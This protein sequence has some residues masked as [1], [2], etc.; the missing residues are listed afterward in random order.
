MNTFPAVARNLDAQQ[1]HPG[2]PINHHVSLFAPNVSSALRK[3]TI[4]PK[5]AEMDPGTQ[6]FKF[7]WLSDGGAPNDKKIMK[8]L[9][10]SWLLLLG[11]NT[12]RLRKMNR[13][14]GSLEWE[15]SEARWLYL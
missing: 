9:R 15:Y 13:K 5:P 10:G 4:S 11:G 8:V 3:R 7:E 2:F 1:M 14:N 6:S 12:M